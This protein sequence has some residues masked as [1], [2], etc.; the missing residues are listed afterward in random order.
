MSETYL[1]GLLESSRNLL[2]IAQVGD[3]IAGFVWAH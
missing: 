3:E 2:V 1:R